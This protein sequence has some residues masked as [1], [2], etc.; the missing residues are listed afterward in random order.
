MMRSIL[1]TCPVCGLEAKYLQSSHA[2]AT[3][4]DSATFHE[5]CAAPHP[6][7]P[8]QCP[9]LDKLIAA[10]ARGGLMLEA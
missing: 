5:L 6:A 9:H 3:E 1:V 7:K 10:V 2:P 8:F 4:F